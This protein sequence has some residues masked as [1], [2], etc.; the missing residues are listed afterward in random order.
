[1]TDRYAATVTWTGSAE[2][3]RS[4]QYSR[5]HEWRFDGHT[6]VRASAG[7]SVPGSDPSAVDPE[8]A[9][10]ASASACH[11]LWFL[12]IARKKGLVVTAYEDQADGEMG[13]NEAG[14]AY[15]AI[16]TL[17]PHVTFEGA[18]DAA[19]IVDC[20]RLAHAECYIANSL[21]AEMRIE[22]R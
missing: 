18:A 12:A 20:H 14:K 10:V 3:H 22:P 16:V 19:L 21:R 13:K 2:D 8:E 7:P 4:G 9:L 5:V 1:M 17:R 15:I 6:V 11:M